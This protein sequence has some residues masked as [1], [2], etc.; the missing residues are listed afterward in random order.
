MKKKVKLSQLLWDAW[1]ILSIIGIWPRFIEPNLLAV[2][3]LRIPIS[4][5]P[6]ALNGLKIIQFSD[7]HWHQT[8]SR[9]F[10]K[11]IESKI[12]ALNPD[13]IVFTGDLLCR[14]KLE[15]PQ[16]LKSFLNALK[17]KIGCFAVLGNHDYAQFVSINNE[18][19][20]AINKKDTSTIR[21]GFKR[22]FCK[23]PIQATISEQ[24]KKV[25]MHEELIAFFKETP[26]QLLHNRNEVI[27]IKDSGINICG[28]G[29]YSLGRIDIPVAF[30]NY[31]DSY[32]GLILVHNPDAIPLLADCSG[33]LILSGHTHGGQINIP[34]IMKRLTYMENY[35]YK[36]GLKKADSKWAYINRGLGSIMQFRWFS[37]PELTLITLDQA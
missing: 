2:N 34:F 1:C 9:R 14:S 18:G 7:L 29:E 27:P 11:K 33:D 6:Q 4:N 35:Q 37:M 12:N 13:I 32:P 15:N 22:L 16:P 25:Q 26:F 31:N 28:L 10:L 8:F 24:A 3:K 20:Y 23:K 5:L 36:R 30:K 17:S 21:Q 19:F